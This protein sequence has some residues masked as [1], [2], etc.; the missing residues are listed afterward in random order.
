M[1]VHRNIPEL[2]TVFE[3]R[4]TVVS[5]GMEELRRML[6]ILSN[7]NGEEYWDVIHCVELLLVSSTGEL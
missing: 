6:K 3:R 5:W 2:G 7:F 4:E 1:C